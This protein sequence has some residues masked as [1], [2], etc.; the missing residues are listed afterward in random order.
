[1]F[2]FPSNL[3][4]MTSVIYSHIQVWLSESSRLELNFVGSWR[5][6]VKPF[7]RSLEMKVMHLR[8]NLRK[9]LGGRMF[10]IGLYTLQ[11]NQQK[12]SQGDV[13]TN[14]WCGHLKLSCGSVC[15]LCSKEWEGKGWEG[16]ERTPGWKL[17]LENLGTSIGCSQQYQVA[18]QT[19][20][21]L[22]LHVF[23]LEMPCLLFWYRSF[24]W[25]STN[26]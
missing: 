14:W 15:L 23:K 3:G 24:K 18:E 10:D 4:K 26:V 20:L 25:D 9:V 2:D 16:L 21:G 5:I 19:D 12:L 11:K 22:W 6:G 17:A 7:S 13:G 1:M 8:L